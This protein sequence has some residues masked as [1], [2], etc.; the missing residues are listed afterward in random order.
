MYKKFLKKIALKVP[1]IKEWVLELDNYRKLVPELEK[2][3]KLSQKKN[4]QLVK[5]LEEERKKSIEIK[6]KI[7]I[8]DKENEHLQVQ[9]RSLQTEILKY[10]DSL[11]NYKRII[12]N[13]NKEIIKYG[14]VSFAQEGED[15][16][17]LA[18]YEGK[19]TYKGFY[20][21]IGA[22]HPY[23]FSNTQVLYEK[24]WRGIN[25]D[26][27]PGSMQL[28]EKYRP[29]DTN[30]E[31]GIGNSES[32]KLTYYMFNE[33]AL[34]GFDKELT[35]DRVKKG[36]KLIGTK[37]IEIF[38][39]NEILNKYMPQNKRID[40]MNI[41]IEGFDIDILKTLEWEKLAP[42][43]LLIEDL[44]LVDKDICLNI[45]DNQIYSILRKHSYKLV[46]KTRR[47]LF[48]RQED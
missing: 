5:A 32:K 6:N 17:L 34:N 29:E 35:E 9:V 40:F 26:A 23:R 22:F 8:M 12:P 46:A 7:N 47:T 10:K 19:S 36:Y 43:F 2:E 18:F 25:I 11:T 21:D 15:L 3:I 4:E 45:K 44:T 38:N 37:D 30:L 24:G 31:I 48:F 16:V 39:I 1:Q 41:D 42:K 33:P 13:L 27:T 28:F 14:R 20:V